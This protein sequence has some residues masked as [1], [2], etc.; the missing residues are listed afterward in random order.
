M[1]KS[2]KRSLVK[3]ML[4]LHSLLESMVRKGGRKERGRGGGRECVDTYL[5]MV[6][7]CPWWS[8]WVELLI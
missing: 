5:G 4:P 6:G 7:V 8:A 1:F 2:L 3:E